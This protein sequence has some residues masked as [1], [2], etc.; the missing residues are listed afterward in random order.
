MAIRAAL[1]FV[2]HPAMQLRPSQ[3]QVAFAEM[4]ALPSFEVERRVGQELADNPAL[5]RVEAAGCGFCGGRAVNCP[6][7]G[8][9]SSRLA[10][11]ASRHS[12]SGGLGAAATLPA[13]E[14]PYDVLL[15]DLLTQLPSAEKPLAE[16]VVGSLDAR[17]YLDGTPDDLACRSRVPACRIQRIIDAL[18][19]LGHPGMAAS[20]LRES[21]LLQLDSLDRHSIGTAPRNGGT[22]AVL[23]RWIVAGYLEALAAGRFS[24]IAQA[25][26]VTVDEVREARAFIQRELTPSPADLV[27]GECWARPQRVPALPDILIIERCDQ[28]GHYLV[29]LAE[30]VRCAVRV[31][32][33]WRAAAGS[34]VTHPEHGSVRVLVRRADGFLAKLEGRW[35]TLQRIG[36]HLVER[37]RGFIQDGPSAM[38]TLTRAEVA[39]A[40]SLCESTVSRAVAGKYALLPDGK[41][42]PLAD[43]FDC[44]LR[45]RTELR[46][47]VAEETHPLSD[48][49]LTALLR[50]RGCHVARRTVAKYRDRLGILPASLRQPSLPGRPELPG[51]SEMPGR[52]ELPGR[53]GAKKTSP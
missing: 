46:T 47:I 36:A 49:E 35:R 2:P 25:L 42:V 10:S 7:C 14:S 11:R 13:E 31:D 3:M 12:G 8:V 52:P 41:I 5:E 15:R 34:A 43:F 45:V 6:V 1:E 50:Q 4:L 17:G 19:E 51:R 24:A 44:S 48:G 33:A 22:G 16:I 38:R 32:P 39:R 28:P 40:L 37:Q 9:H 29:E 30:A 27:A 23:A 26:D 20:S 53:P 21:L 18:R